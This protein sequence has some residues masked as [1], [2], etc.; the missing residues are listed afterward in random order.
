M[1]ACVP[2]PLMLYDKLLKFSPCL[3]SLSEKTGVE[4]H[5]R[6]HSCVQERYIGFSRSHTGFWRVLDDL[7]NQAGLIEDDDFSDSLA[8]PFNASSNSG[9]ALV[10]RPRILLKPGKPEVASTV[11]AGNIRLRAFCE[12][13][14]LAPKLPNL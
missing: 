13:L 7:C 8:T 10:R 11:Y 4:F 1:S 9:V 6:N 14:T 5:L 3:G 12:A 2:P